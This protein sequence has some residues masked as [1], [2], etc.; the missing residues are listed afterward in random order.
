[1]AES[2]LL[3]TSRVGAFARG[4]AVAVSATLT[5]TL[6]TTF[7][8][9]TARRAVSAGRT[10]ALTLQGACGFLQGGGNNLQRGVEEREVKHNF[11]G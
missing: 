2:D 11:A 3:G 6:A 5:T 4:A 1:M 10:L 8:I 7:T 9:K